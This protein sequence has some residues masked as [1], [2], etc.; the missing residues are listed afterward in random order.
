MAEFDNFTSSPLR[1]SI[2]VALEDQRGALDL[3]VRFT[4][5]PGW[6][7]LF[8]P[9]GSGKSTILRLLAGL[10]RPRAGRIALLPAAR[11]TRELTLT[12]TA[13]GIHIPPER[14]GVRLLAQRPALFPHRS[15]LSNITYARQ[16]R[17]E[18]ADHGH[19]SRLDQI[20]ALCGVGPL[21]SRRLAGL[22]GG[23]QQRVALART[24]MAQPTHLLLLD[25]PF[26]GLAASLRDTLIHDLRAWLR[27]QG[28]PVLLVTHDLGEVFATGGTV[29]RLESGH[30]TETGPATTVLA[31]ER[32]AMLHRMSICG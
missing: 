9:S 2:E 28:T 12:D 17:S 4:L 27:S 19:Q 5:G 31:A 11:D 20:I 25:E 29:M 7:V 16:R 24:L 18:Q 6:S 15:V 10:D 13:R 30:I 26:T 32:A 14:R 3:A 22:S 1:F 23:E 21:L 8:G